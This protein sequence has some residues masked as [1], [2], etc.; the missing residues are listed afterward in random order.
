MVDS[1]SDAVESSQFKACRR[2]GRTAMSQA[3]YQS[4]CRGFSL[5][6]G[7]GSEPGSSEQGHH[8]S[9]YLAA[10]QVRGCRQTGE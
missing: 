9:L 7:P 8:P 1:T 10:L 4:G 2:P 3:R 6:Q 5:S